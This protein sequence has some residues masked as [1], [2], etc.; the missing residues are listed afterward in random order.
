MAQK[1]KLLPLRHS[2]HVA[3]LGSELDA[4][5]YAGRAGARILNASFG[6]VHPPVALER[7]LIASFPN[8]LFVAAAGNTQGGHDN[9]ATLSYPCSYDLPNILC[10]AATDNRDA[11]AS[12]SHFGRTTVDLAAPGVAIDSSYPAYLAFNQ[13]FLSGDDLFARG[14]WQRTGGSV[15]WGQQDGFATASPFAF[16]DS[17]NGPYPNGQDTTAR[18][19]AFSLA[20]RSGCRLQLDLNLAASG[21]DGLIPY[22]STD[23]VNFAALGPGWT[24]V[25]NGFESV[26]AGLSSLDGAPQVFVLL[27]FTSNN[28][29]FVGDGAL[30]DQIVVNCP[31]T[32]YVGAEREFA[33]NDG[34]SMA[35]PHVAGAAAL[36]LARHPQLTVAQVKDALMRSAD[37]LPALAGRTVTGGRLNA[38]RALEIADAIAAPAPPPPPAPVQ[39]P[40]LAASPGPARDLA[41][42]GAP[43]LAGRRVAVPVSCRSPAVGACRGTVRVRARVPAGAAAPRARCSPGGPPTGSPSGGRR[44]SGRA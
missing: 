28:D 18:S 13:P 37:P 12:F 4:V 33:S 16:A 1:V 42:L 31:Q 15:R 41:A 36:I 17:P 40:T 38:R 2:F 30:V 6:G 24:G 32:T 29:G 43:S 19:P 22:A 3:T 27:R 10:V 44:W 39:A 14:V 8:M 35:A 9:D 7:D 5:G 25:S 34:T 20:G 23:G 21:G 11:L 26:S